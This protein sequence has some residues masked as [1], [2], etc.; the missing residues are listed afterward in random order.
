MKMAVLLRSF[1]C[2]ALL[3]FTSVGAAATE[4]AWP[5]GYVVHSTSPN[6][7]LGIVIPGHDLGETEDETAFENFVANLKTH[8]VLGKIQEADYFERQN[9]RGLEVTWAPDSSACVL[10][11]DGRFGYGTIWLV[12]IKGPRLVVTDIGKHITK[13]LTSAVGE[14]GTDSAWFR[15]APGNKLLVRALTY[16][17][18][19]KIMDEKTRQARFNGTYDR[20]AKKWIVS[21]ARRTKDWETLSSAYSAG[22][23]GDIFV[24][25]GG[26]Q[27]KVPP[28]FSGES[29]NS[30]EE[31]EQA[32]DL[33]MNNVYSALKLLL[34]SAKFAKLK[35]EQIAWLKKRDAI[36]VGQRS[37]LITARIKALEEF[38]WNKKA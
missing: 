19:P 8:R 33:G 4:N 32:L 13:I 28:E 29:V 17:G 16:T 14:E 15:F 12:E 9:H 26:D 18:N 27:S 38:L 10:T 3:F 6:G 7:Q 2:V 21:E 22:R 25:P 24:A 31:K 35:Q 1:V 34:P 11:Y 5:D 30:E 36:P 23:G 37:E 20:V